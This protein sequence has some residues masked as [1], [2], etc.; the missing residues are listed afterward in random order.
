MIVTRKRAI[1]P[2]GTTRARQD[3]RNSYESGLLRAVS[4]HGSHTRRACGARSL[5]VVAEKR[6]ALEGSAISAEDGRRR[7]RTAQDGRPSA[8]EAGNL[9]DVPGKWCR[10][11]RGPSVPRRWKSV[12][13]EEEG[14]ARLPAS[15]LAR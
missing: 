4:S 15:S 3:D 10:G 9:S 14:A 7:R 6:V 2:A 8:E 11:D 1:R 12:R 13:R 5:C